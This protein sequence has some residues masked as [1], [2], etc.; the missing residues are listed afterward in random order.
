[1]TTAIP[2]SSTGLSA[3][4][5]VFLANSV[6]GC[7]ESRMT[8]SPTARYGAD[9]GET[10]PATSC[11]AATAAPTASSPSP[12]PIQPWDGGRLGLGGGGR[13]H[14]TII[15]GAAPGN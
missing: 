14:P 8:T 4:P 11:P 3:V 13:G 6:S 5:K 12:A 1:M 2:A 10:S 9:A 15:T 7:G